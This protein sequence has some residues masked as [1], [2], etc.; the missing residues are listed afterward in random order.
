MDKVKVL[1]MIND[2]ID[3]AKGSITKAQIHGNRSDIRYLTGSLEAY[4]GIKESIENGEW[5]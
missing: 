1:L 5:G 3:W 2:K 4:E